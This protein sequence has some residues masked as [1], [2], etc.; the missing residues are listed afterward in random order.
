MFWPGHTQPVKAILSSSFLAVHHLVTVS[1]CWS[2]FSCSVLSSIA[3]TVDSVPH[4]FSCGNCCLLSGLHTHSAD[5]SLL[6]SQGTCLLVLYFSR[7]LQ[8][9]TCV[10]HCIMMSFW[11]KHLSYMQC[12]IFRST[13]K[14]RPNNIRG[15]KCPSVRPSVRPQKVSSISMKFGI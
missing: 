3:S 12:S 6:C 13:S 9:F 1:K 11:K 5:L 7:N 8:H 4:L 14:S 15:G 2:V 10:H